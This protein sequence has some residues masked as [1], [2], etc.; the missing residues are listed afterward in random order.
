MNVGFAPVGAPGDGMGPFR[1]IFDRGVNLAIVKDLSN[2]D[3]VLLWGGSDISPSLYDEARYRNSGPDSPTPR[4]IF[5]WSLIREADERGIPVIGICRGAQLMCAYVGGKLVQDVDNHNKSHSIATVDDKSFFV[6]SCHHQMM[7]PFDVEH[8]MLAW[9]SKH[10]STVYNPKEK[11]YC[12]EMEKHFYKE[13]EVVF[14]PEIKGYGIQCH[15]EWHT[16]DDPFNAWIMESIVEKC[17]KD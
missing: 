5:E 6:T 1:R 10:Q 14:F 4:D 13:P 16:E 12:Q 8:E 3:A 17:F 11:L 9:S 7:Y 2:I 15:P